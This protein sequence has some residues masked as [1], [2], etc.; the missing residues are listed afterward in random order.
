MTRSAAPR[1]STT[2]RSRRPTRSAGKRLADL[3]LDAL[4]AAAEV[5]DPRRAA[6]R[7]A[8][9]QRRRP[10][11]VMAAQRRSGLVVD[12]RPLAVRAG[13]D[14]AAVAAQ[15]D[16]RRPAPV[17]DED[18]LVAAGRVERAERLG[19]RAR[20]QAAVARGQLRAEVDDLDGRRRAGRPRRQHDPVVARRRGRGRRCRPP[21]SPSRGRPRRR[22]GARAR[23]AASRAWR[24]GVRSL[25]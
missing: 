16:R 23:I 3:A 25:L 4:R 1:C 8:R 17:E 20:E 15:H 5:A 13:L 18:R 21:A 19:Q 6:G 7:A 10:A 22:P 14:V 24:R 11:A 2:S 12:E 9:G